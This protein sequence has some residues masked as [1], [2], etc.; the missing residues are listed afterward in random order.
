MLGITHTF[1]GSQEIKVHIDQRSG[2]MGKVC[3]VTGGSHGI[4]CG[5]ARVL[6]EVGYNLVVA[7]LS[8][9]R[10]CRGGQEEIQRECFLG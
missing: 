8:R 5:T 2:K 3:I 10:K 9:R 4:E 7:Q 6:A 1:D